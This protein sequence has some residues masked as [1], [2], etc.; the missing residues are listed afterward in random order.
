HVQLP[1][2]RIQHLLALSGGE[3]A[4]TAIALL[5]AMLQV[6]PSPFY[7]LDEID[8]A[9]DEANLTRFR[10]LLEEAAQTAQFIVITH[11]ATTMEAAGVLY[12][13]TAAQPGV[14]TLVSIDLQQAAATTA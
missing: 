2:R 8:A 6:N 4:L 1:G 12:G 11:R 5:F 7:V 14:S 10:R 13:V 3:R 9:L